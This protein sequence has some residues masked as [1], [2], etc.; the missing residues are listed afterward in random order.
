MTNSAICEDPRNTYTM[1]T[2]AGDSFAVSVK[3]G[4]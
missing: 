2:E 4:C 3:G 1:Q